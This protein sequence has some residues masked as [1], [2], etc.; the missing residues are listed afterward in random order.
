MQALNSSASISFDPP[1]RYPVSAARAFSASTRSGSTTA[2]GSTTGSRVPSQPASSTAAKGN[3]R[4]RD[5]WPKPTPG[6]DCSRHPSRCANAGRS[7][8]YICNNIHIQ[9]HVAGDFCFPRLPHAR[10]RAHT[11]ARL[12]CWAAAA[13]AWAVE[14]DPRGVRPLGTAAARRERTRTQCNHPRFQLVSAGRFRP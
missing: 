5:S 10:D 11:C 2:A 3:P 7:F 6:A 14:G 9:A 12:S 4:T 8:D 13:P 1:G